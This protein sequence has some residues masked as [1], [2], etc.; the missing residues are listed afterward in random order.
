MQNLTIRSTIVIGE[1]YLTNSR[2]TI[3]LDSIKL[4]TKSEK[5]SL[6]RISRI[7]IVL[8]D[9]KIVQVLGSHEVYKLICEKA[10]LEG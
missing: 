7:Y 5:E 6:T 4:V 3:R 8:K 1:T 9:N 2:Y 10:N